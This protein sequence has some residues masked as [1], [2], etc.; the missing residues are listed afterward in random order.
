MFISMLGKGEEKKS[1]K[2][3]GLSQN[4]GGGSLNQ[5]PILDKRFLGTPYDHFRKPQ[6]RFILGSIPQSNC[7]CI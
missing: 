5:T 7:K 1:C 6:A 4:Q 3:Y 2:K